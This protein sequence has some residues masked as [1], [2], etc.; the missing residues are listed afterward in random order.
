MLKKLMASVGVAAALTLGTANVSQAIV[1]ADVIWLIDTSGSMIADI[2]EVKTNLVAFNAAMILNGIDAHHALV[3]FGGMPPGGNDTDGTALLSIDVTD[4]ATFAATA[5]TLTAGGAGNEPGSL[6]VTTALSGATFRA[7]SV[8]N[9]ILITDE[10]D[11]SSGGE[12][13]AADTALDDM[14]AFFN[15]IGVP[16]VGNTD[17][18]YGAL[19]DDH[20]GT[21]FEITAFR[22][23][24]AGFF[25]NFIDTKVQEILGVPEPTTMAL[26]GLGLAGL[27]F[28]RRRKAA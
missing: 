28:A 5:S 1:V 23:D 11:D 16:G 9:L 6:A 10:D 2:E 20:G 25:A 27:G 26:F 24:P 21:A 17:A 7:G 15:F 4:F 8:K 13:S 19:A 12:F 3:E 18:R 22:A 14:N